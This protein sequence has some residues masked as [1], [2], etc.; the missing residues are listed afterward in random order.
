[1]DSHRMASVGRDIQREIADILRVEIDDPLI[2]FVSITE[3][4]VSPDLKHAKVFFSVLGDEDEKENAGRGLRR[5]GKFIR[6]RLAERMELRYVPRLRFHLDETAER[7][8]RIEQLL[9]AEEHELA[10]E[11]PDDDAGDR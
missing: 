1:M 10:G 9:R 4:E 3:V 2:G 8:Q 7:A 6:G 5:A 11:E